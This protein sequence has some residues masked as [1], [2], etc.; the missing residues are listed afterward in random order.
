M[1]LE[2]LG[3]EGI[4]HQIVLSKCD[5]VSVKNGDMRSAFEDTKYL[6]SNGLGGMACLGEL[7]GVSGDPSRK[8]PKIGISE[9]RWS[10]LTACGLEMNMGKDP[11]RVK[12][13]RYNNQ[14]ED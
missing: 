12:S 5:R 14:Y 6:I 11:V 1:I 3:A 10:I 9:L 2:K 8:G 13:A 7:L 4:P